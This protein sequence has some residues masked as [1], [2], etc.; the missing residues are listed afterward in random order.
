MPFKPHFSWDF[1]T[2]DEI[3]ERSLRALKNHIDYLKRDSVYYRELLQYFDSSDIISLDDIQK[4]PLTK[5]DTLFGDCCQFFVAS[6]DDVVETVLAINDAN[7]TLLFPITPSDL[8]RLAYSGSLSFHGAG[9][10]VTDSAQIW[11]SM[12]NMK[13]S[14]MAYYRGLIALGVNSARI[15]TGSAEMHK[16]YLESMQPTVIVGVPSEIYRIGESIRKTGYKLSESSVQ[17]IFCVG[18]PIRTESLT[19]TEVGSS[20][21]E[22][23]GASVFSCY[24]STEMSSTFTEC[25]EQKG[26]H[27]HHELV[28]VEI[29]DK[30]GKPVPDGEMGEL[31]VTPFGVEGMPLLR[32]CTGDITYKISEK[33]NCGRNS[34]RIGPIKPRETTLIDFKD[35]TLNPAIITKTI[36]SIPDVKDYLIE[37]KGREGSTSEE[38]FIH[39]AT[40]PGNVLI[41][42]TRVKEAVEVTIPVLISNAATLNS[43]RGEHDK[44]THFIDNRKKA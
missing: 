5:K 43:L 30:S 6:N 23:F 3:N 35:T 26:G 38:V 34:T 1:L 16:N 4:L 36:E 22:I 39:A 2:P 8:D 14:G 41:I 19:L 25:S 37:L 15:G 9:V 17:K 20:I 44:D 10:S 29:L 42:M 7:E 21:E 18:E 24:S 32:Y 33:C 12:D 27:T 11:V 31:V 40:K 13:M 28:Y